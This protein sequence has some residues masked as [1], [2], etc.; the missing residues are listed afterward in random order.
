MKDRDLGFIH[1]YV[2]GKRN[3][4]GST[5]LLLHGTG[6][7][8]TS[9]A[10]L[11]ELLV[12]GAALLSPRGKVLE[13]GMP[14]FF[15]RVAEGVFDIE[16]LEFRTKELAGFVRSATEVYGLDSSKLIAVG[17]SNGANITASLMLLEPG[18]LRTAVLFRAMVPFE[19]EV[20]PDLTGTSV[21]MASG[22]RDQLVAPSNAA[23]LAEILRGAGAE[24]ELRWTDGGHRL[25][26]E[27][28]SEANAWLSRTMGPQPRDEPGDE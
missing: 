19:P 8:E 18:L 2:P 15:R 12:P 28:V 22:L 14:R 9:L 25:L 10:Q 11:G 13:N 26:A 21:Y 3:G 1:R 5:L 7:D 16:D 27:D 4:A 23:R 6:G 20:P 24:V 17:Y